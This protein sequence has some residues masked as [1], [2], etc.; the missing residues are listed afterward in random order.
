MADF[1]RGIKAGVAAA[2]V[3]LVLSVLL[4]AIGQTFYFRSDLVY[5]AGLGFHFEFVDSFVLASSIWSYVFR[6]IV[7]GAIFAALYSFLPAAT[8]VRK[9][10]VLSGFLWIVGAVGAIYMTLGWPGGG[11][12]TVAGLLPVSLSSMGLTLVSILS[13]LAFGALVGVIWRRLAAK[14]ASEARSGAPTLLVGWTLGVLNWA[15]AAVGLTVV[16]VVGG[17]SLADLVQLNGALWWY[18]V[19]ALSVVF[20]GL[21]GWVLALL[22]WRKGRGGES[23]FGLGVAGGI[24]MVLT[25][26]MLLPGVLAIIGDILSRREHAAE[27]TVPGIQQLSSQNRGTAAK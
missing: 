23:G 11:T 4:A 12:S 2:G 14:E 20:L 6:G 16:V 21:P 22:A 10:V 8:S 15:T 18:G 5:A 19:L 9:G 27:T 13:A 7:F 24:C 26:M 1:R 25:G 17:V 3:Y